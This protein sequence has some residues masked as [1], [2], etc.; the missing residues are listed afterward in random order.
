MSDEYPVIE[1][2][3][4]EGNE[5]KGWWLLQNDFEG[6]DDLVIGTVFRVMPSG[7]LFI[8]KRIVHGVRMVQ[9]FKE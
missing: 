2:G 1:L 4:E 7:S 9:R 6:V 5:E 3:I 8:V